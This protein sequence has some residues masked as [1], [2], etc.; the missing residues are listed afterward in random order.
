[1]SASIVIL[2]MYCIED[3]CRHS[4]SSLFK[5]TSCFVFLFFFAL[6]HKKDTNKQALVREKM[7]AKAWVV[8]FMSTVYKTMVVIP[9]EP[10]SLSWSGAY[11]NS[12][13]NQTICL[14]KTIKS[15]SD[16]WYNFMHCVLANCEMFLTLLSKGN[17]IL[18]PL[19]VC[20]ASGFNI[21]TCYCIL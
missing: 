16:C 18:I 12:L 15:P 6:F 21:P 13:G 11:I 20:A 17:S 3:N 10:L 4:I 19:M 9:N 1:M 2:E 8:S 5:P 7:Q 14:F